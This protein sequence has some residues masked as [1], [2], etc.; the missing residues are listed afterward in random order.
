MLQNRGPRESRATRRWVVTYALLVAVSLV[1]LAVSSAGPIQDLR[2][3]INFAVSPIQGALAGT[4]RSVTSIVGAI[5]EIDQLRR[6]NRQLGDR[7]AELETQI[8]QYATLRGE[9]ERLSRLLGL[10][11]TLEYGT[12]AAAVIGRQATE[13]ERVITLDRGTDAG[14][15]VGDPCLSEGGALVGAVVDA[16]SNYSSVMLIS[17]TRSV[18]I[19]LDEASRATGEV[20]GRLSALLAMAH[21]PTTEVVTPD[22]TVVTAG[23]DLGTGSQAP[24]PRGLLIG[25]VVEVQNDA[26][27]VVQT[28]LIQPAA[29][30]DDLEHVLVITDFESV[31][32]PAPGA[33]PTPRG[34]AGPSPTLRR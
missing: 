34:S 15:A 30:L 25:R 24:F 28:A 17:D 32:V 20:Q 21:I 33:S 14:I 29:D 4:T 13:V 5:G 1:L 18:V 27:A 12:V 3:G 11:A 9:N 23:L 8:Q 26:S 22:D 2:R 7:V 16:G 31:A 6:E 19:G 10:K